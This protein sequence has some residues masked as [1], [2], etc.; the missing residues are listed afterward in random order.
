MIPECMLVVRICLRVG[1]VTMPSTGLRQARKRRNGVFLNIGFHNAIV[2]R[3][4][5]AITK[6]PHGCY[7]R[8][9]LGSLG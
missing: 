3:V 7:G 8:E 2:L 9:Y 5:E 4:K 6:D 1:W